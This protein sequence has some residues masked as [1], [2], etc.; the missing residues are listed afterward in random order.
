MRVHQ[1]QERKFKLKNA[2]PTFVYAKPCIN[3][4]QLGATF[5]TSRYVTAEETL[6][7]SV[8]L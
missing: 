4:L 6:K 1:F 8:L 7:R 3:N 2:Q 5:D